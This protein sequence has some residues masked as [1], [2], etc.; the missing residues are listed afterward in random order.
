M[1]RGSSRARKNANADRP[2]V[3][4]P[5][6]PLEGG[7]LLTAA[8][9]VLS[10]LRTDLEARASD[11]GVT[12]ALELRYEEEKKHKLTG[13]SFAAWREARVAQIAASWFLSCVFVRTLEDRGLLGQARLAGAGA[14]DSQA[15]F[16]QLAP[17]LTER[18]YLLFVFRELAELPA[19][20]ALFDRAHALVWQ[21]SPSAEA[22][23]ELLRLFRTP[24]AEAPAFRFGQA[25]TRFLGD[26]Y[27]DL[28]EDVRKRFALLQTPDFVERFIL[29]RTLEPAIERFGLDDTTLID[30]TC[31]SG[32]FLL[33]AFERLFEHRLRQTPGLDV[34]QAAQRAL[35]AVFGADINPYAVAIA[36]MRL[37]LAFLEK[38]GIQKLKD[39][40][41]PQLHL[42]VADSLRYNPQHA[43]LAMEHHATQDAKAWVG[44]AFPLEDDMAARDVLLHQYAA[45]VGNPPYITEKDPAKRETYRAMYPRSA[46]GK[47]A[48]SA[49]FCERFFQLA[50]DRGYVGQIT[51]NSFMKREFGEALIEEYLKDVNLE[52]II[53]TSGAYIPGHGTPTVLLFGTHEPPVAREVG[54]V[55]AK[56]GEPSTPADPAK[57][58][59][60]SSIASHWD[61]LGF[62]NDYISVARIDR[63]KLAKHPWSLGGGGAVELKELLEERAA[64][65]LANVISTMG[66]D[67]I[68]R[69]ADLLE[70]PKE[71][72]LRVG[73]E[74][75]L[76][77]P[78]LV[79][80]DIRDWSARAMSEIPVPYSRTSWEL[81]DIE[82][83]PGL[84][85]FLWPHR[86]W[87]RERFV[88]GGT[89]M[90][91]VGLPY[92]AIPQLPVD[93]HRTP[94]S[95]AFAEVATHNHFVLDRGGKVFKQTAPIIKLPADATEDDHLALLAYLNSSTACFWMKQVCFPKGSATRD[96]MAL[97]NNRHAFSATA[98]LPLPLP[99]RSQELVD[100]G[101]RA[102]LLARQLA[103]I[104]PEAVL[105]RTEDCGDH[106]S[107]A[108]LLYASER[109]HEAISGE[110]RFVQEE[111]DW[112]V[113][114]LFG[115]AEEAPLEH[116]V[117][118]GADARPYAWAGSEPPVSVPAEIRAG[119]ASRRR[120]IESDPN[121][122][123]IENANTKRLWRGTSGDAERYGET[124]RER[125]VKAAKLWLAERLEEE[126]GR[127]GEI[128][129]PRSFAAAIQGTARFVAV[130]TVVS[131][132][133]AL[134]LHQVIL[135]I[136][137]G[138]AVPN[139]RAQVYTE[140]GLIK[141][142]AWEAVWCQQRREDA[143][144]PVGQIPVPP[145]YS[146]GSR[147]KATDFIRDEYWQLRGKLDVPKERFISYPGC[148]SDQDGEP[149]YGWAGW[150]HL[151]RALALANL[152][153]K[154]KT[155]EGWTAERLTPMLAGLLELLPWIQQW[156]NELDPEYGQRMGDYFAQFL[157]GELA[158]LGLTRAQLEAWRPT[159]RASRPAKA[160][161]TAPEPASPD[162]AQTP[163]PRRGRRGRATGA[164]GATGASD[165][166]TASAGATP[167]PP[168][169]KKRAAVEGEPR[170][171]PDDHGG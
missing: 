96:S 58:E 162:A 73:V 133:A 144:E 110:L 126:V 171:E 116:A 149:V 168:R 32:H 111:V 47:Y 122:G 2:G 24:T 49:P 143:G 61:E 19:S 156:H 164:T 142:A 125:T 57:G 99:P 107:L 31:G 165:D 86:V 109:R 127:H 123:Q 139:L 155:E 66:V 13:D 8:R 12:R 25:K 132:H 98:L 89:R 159:R 59:V 74:E 117:S 104:S 34:R 150:N 36:R 78:C 80:E 161:S 160:A 4:D 64:T 120:K 94:L 16:F 114:R 138:R 154:R 118:I 167:K 170:G 140:S 70:L 29:D 38:A 42:V 72:A 81:S 124:Y 166:G 14:M 62:E 65:N 108:E 131:G 30:P 97:E 105:A 137:D 135:D 53:N 35:D 147:G 169:R 54:A 146:Q 77:M 22:A 84:A 60:W 6:A 52:R 134:D 11:P 46:A 153:Q 157:D 102:D 152:Y 141:R 21:L 7:E 15:M 88:S 90:S 5:T 27:Q 33:G 85:R 79:G 119:Y 93:K 130:A 100:L 91:D 26:L 129:G 87:L 128:S 56:R 23:K 3:A 163:A 18:D 115:L 76:L 68:T 106:S 17:S 158:T 28:Y 148:E 121:L 136:L 103:A 112:L 92:W 41:A 95:I 113:Y 44:D 69:A 83:Y 51:A 48:L 40:P 145:A 9:P 101:S 45:V 71:T 20:R 82:S 37:T 39:A 10:Q 67:T 63:D 151:Q 1:A 50:R 75:T 43:Q 55:L